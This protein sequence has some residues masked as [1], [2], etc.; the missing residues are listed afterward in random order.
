MGSDRGARRTLGGIALLVGIVGIVA[1]CGTAPAASTTPLTV[2]DAWARPAGIGGESAAYLTITNPGAADTLLSVRCAIAASTVL[3]QTATD[4]SGMTGMS[5]LDNLPVPAGAT[6]RLEP[7]GT[8]V[9][10][11]NLAQP[12]VIGRTVEL[13]L[14]FEHAGEIVVPVAIRAG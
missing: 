14:V 7:G 8:H 3:H 6:V 5:M 10:I 1:A 4:S 12:L 11:G 9:M 13:R 2:V